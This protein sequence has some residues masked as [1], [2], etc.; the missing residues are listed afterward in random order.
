MVNGAGVSARNACRG[1]RVLSRLIATI[2]SPWSAYFF[3][4]VA[5]HGNDRWHGPHHEAQKST[6]TTLAAQRIERDGRWGGGAELPAWTAAQAAARA[7]RTQAGWREAPANR[8]PAAVRAEGSRARWRFPIVSLLL[9]R[10]ACLRRTRIRRRR[11]VES[12]LSGPARRIAQ[13]RTS[14]SYTATRAARSPARDPAGAAAFAS[15]GHVGR[16]IAGLPRR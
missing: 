4:I 6:S 15:A 9:L 5:I 11:T 7:R 10:A 8:A 14:P 2:V 1:F 13:L 16:R 12:S 3:C